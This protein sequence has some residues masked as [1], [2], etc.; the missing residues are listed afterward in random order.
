[1]T[2]TTGTTLGDPNVAGGV[3]TPRMTINE[4]DIEADRDTCRRRQENTMNLDAEGNVYMQWWY[5]IYSQVGRNKG[6]RA[7]VARA[8]HTSRRRKQ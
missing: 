2:E 4:A 8:H 7:A 6:P 5:N 3:P 1:M